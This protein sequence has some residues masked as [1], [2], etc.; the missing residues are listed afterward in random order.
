MKGAAV[1]FR[2]AH[3]SENCSQRNPY[4]KA[5]ATMFSRPGLWCRVWR[6]DKLYEKSS[7]IGDNFC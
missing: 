7:P 3:P 2:R 6:P 1:L 4:Q 5:G